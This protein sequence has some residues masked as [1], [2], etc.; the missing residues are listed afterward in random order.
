MKSEAALAFA[1]G[2]L[3]GRRRRMRWAVALA[4]MAAGKRLA[5]G[6]VPVGTDA[7]PTSEI[8]KV[9]RD[10]RGKVASAGRSAVVS[11]ASNRMNALSDRLERR[12]NTLRPGGDTSEKPD[13]S[14]RQ[15]T[16]EERD[17]SEQRG[18]SG[19][20]EAKGKARERK[21]ASAARSGGRSRSEER[22]RGGER[23]RSEDRRRKP[24]A[25][26]PAKTR[27]RSESGG[28]GRRS[29]G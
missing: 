14:E 6:R 15:E 5:S 4:G 22:T 18:T 12:A 24:A 16:S 8:G 23:S 1:S 3:F 20:R 13:G 25:D 19:K 28:S 2:Y 10:V 9:G 7:L 26:R 11:V 27:K 17:A 29:Q 21:D